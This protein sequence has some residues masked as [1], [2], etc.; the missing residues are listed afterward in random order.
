M[1]RQQQLPEGG[2]FS[3]AISLSDEQSYFLT[4]GAQMQQITFVQEEGPLPPHRRPPQTRAPPSKQPPAAS[5]PS[6]RST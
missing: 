5:C 2:P 3:R 1:L 6:P 4:L